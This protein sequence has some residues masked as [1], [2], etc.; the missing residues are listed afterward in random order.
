MLGVIFLATVSAT[1]DATFLSVARAE[2]AVF[3][4][5]S[6]ANRTVQTKRLVDE[7]LLPNT[8]CTF[9]E[10]TSSRGNPGGASCLSSALG[11]FWPDS[12][13]QLLGESIQS[14]AAA[15]K[16]CLGTRGHT[17]PVRMEYNVFNGLV[18]MV[19]GAEYA[20][21]VGKTPSARKRRKKAVEQAV[22]E[23]CD[24]SGRCHDVID[25][26]V[27]DFQSYSGSPGVTARGTLRTSRPRWSS[28]G[29]NGS[30]V[31]RPRK[32]RVSRSI[33]RFAAGSRFPN[34]ARRPSSDECRRS[35]CGVQRPSQ[36]RRYRRRADP[37]VRDRTHHPILWNRASSSAPTR[38]TCRRRCSRSPRHPGPIFGPKAARAFAPP[39]RARAGERRTRS[40]SDDLSYATLLEVTRF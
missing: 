31:S 7:L 8:T 19:Q 22:S 29:T 39:S 4:D 18:S 11:R 6:E 33:A 14:Q 26:L 9:L 21:P 16:E 36:A 23:T 28:T 30:S 35:V 15:Y 1:C 25:R 20:Y 10:D 32:S 24:A 38:G 13:Q 37:S 2:M 5:P 12:D 34:T 40:S 17:D 3:L 27:W